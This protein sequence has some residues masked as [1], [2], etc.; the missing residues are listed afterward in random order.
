[1]SKY[2]LERREFIQKMIAL[3]LTVSGAEALF[4]ITGCSTT[5]FKRDPASSPRNL[6]ASIAIIGAGAA[7]ISAAHFLRAKGYRKVTIYEASGDVGGKCN[8]IDIE[9][10]AYDMG[11]V[12]TTSSYDE[13][14]ALAKAYQVPVVPLEAH[15]DKNMVD[16]K[17]GVARAWTIPETADLGL[18]GYDYK[19]RVLEKYPGLIRPGFAG[20]DP[21]LFVPLSEWVGKYSLFPDSLN[22][23]FGFTFTPFGYGFVDEV[24]AAYALK[25]YEKR[26]VGSL[27]HGKN[28]GMVRDG[29]QSLWRAVAKG[30]DIRLN[31]PVIK[32]RRFESGQLEVHTGFSV[33]FYD[34]LIVTSLPEDTLNF[35]DKT[36]EEENDLGRAQRYFYYSLA[37]KTPRPLDPKKPPPLGETGFMPENYYPNRSPHPLCWFK[38]WHA[39]DI[40]IFYALSKTELSQQS[41]SDTLQT[42]GKKYGWKLGPTLAIRKWKYFPHF[43]SADLADGIYDRMEARQGN[44]NTYIAGEIMNFS[45]VEM[46]TRYSK[47]LVHRFF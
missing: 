28:L 30:M 18:A 33:D 23:F 22:E 2:D 3:G 35:L 14:L 6:N 46:V 42:D 24:P 39:G 19:L 36:P 4:A 34:H 44:L 9:G 43:S 41:V 1:M 5:N 31:T 20:L 45:T 16:I 11:A 25:Y 7:G 29:Y 8:T 12:F 27:L 13:V 26:L 32:T 47:D 17:T 40:T 37:V 10:R 15:A 38:R 21:E